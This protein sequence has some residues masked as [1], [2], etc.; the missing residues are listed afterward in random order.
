MIVL[1]S[2]ASG[3]SFAGELKRSDIE[4]VSVLPRSSDVKPYPMVMPPDGHSSLARADLH[5]DEHRSPGTMLNSNTRS[6][7]ISSLEKKQRTPPLLPNALPSG[8]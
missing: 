5:A 2:C 7:E 6:A 1:A 8:D 4:V 3:A